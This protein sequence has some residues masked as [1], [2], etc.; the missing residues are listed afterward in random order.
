[1]VTKLAFHGGIQQLAFGQLD[2]GIRKLFHIVARRRP[3]QVTAIGSRAWVFGLL[4]S[5]VFKLGTF[6]NAGND[7]FGLFFFF[8]QDVAGTVLFAAVGRYKLVV[9]GLD[10]VIGHG[11]VLLE[12]AKQLANQDGL[13]AQI[14]L[15]FEVIIGVQ[16]LALR[17]LHKEFTGNHLFFKLA[18]HFWRH[19][20]SCF[21]QLLRQSFHTCGGYGLAIDDGHVLRKSRGYHAA[22]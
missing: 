8:H 18:H 1:M 9:L 19:R 14:H 20:P 5:D 16:A 13:A 3:I 21:G 2:H 10:L 17:L 7:G 22:Q 15:G 4:F 6:F 11:V 12:G